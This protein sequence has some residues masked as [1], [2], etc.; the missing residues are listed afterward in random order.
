MNIQDIKIEDI[1]VI[2]NVRVSIKD[3][4]IK[5]LMES[6]KQHGLKQ[7]I[8]VTPS[9]DGKF[10]LIYGHRRLT[11]CQKLGYKTIA[12]NVEDSIELKDLL[13]L[14]VTENIQR[15]DITPSELGRICH[16]LQEMDMTPGEIS[17]RLGIGNSR[18]TQAISIYNG[19]PSKHRNKVR[20]MTGSENKKG[21]ISATVVQKLL[22]CKREYGLS[23]SAIDKLI[24]EIKVKEM[25]SE[26]INILSGLI[27]SGCTATQA[28]AEQKQYKCFRIDIVL[29]KKEL[30]EELIKFKID[31]HQELVKQIIYGSVE[32]N[33]TKPNFIKINQPVDK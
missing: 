12:A 27:E 14:N 24:D 10:V 18:V 5:E 1:E 29:N 30:D 17:T 31:S 23:D 15:K 3:E 20:F 25:T 8:G 11:A 33:L 21:K 6:I 28:L 22:R 16:R 19:L 13:L 9:N 2:E 4:T 7:A 26:D 32:T